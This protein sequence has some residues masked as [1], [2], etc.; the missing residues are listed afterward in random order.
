MQYV[1]F[2][3]R[4]SISDDQGDRRIEGIKTLHAG[5]MQEGS[6]HRARCKRNHTNEIFHA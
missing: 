6:V 1:L 2:I 4:G 5:F 3:S